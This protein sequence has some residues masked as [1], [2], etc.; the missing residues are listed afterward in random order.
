VSEATHGD[1][2]R[3]YPELP[4]TAHDHLRP[5]V[6]LAVNAGLRRGELFGLRWEDV[7]L[8]NALLTVVG[9]TAK[10]GTTRYVPLN[11]EAIL[12]FTDWMAPTSDHNGL[13]VSGK[14]GGRLDNINTAWR[15]LMKK[16]EITGF[17]FHDLRHHLASKLVRA[18]IDLD[19][20]RELLGH[21]DIKMTL[22]YAHLAPEHKAAAV[23]KLVAD[24]SPV[25]GQTEM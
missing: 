2:R 8:E 22:R 1:E 18:G 4:A 17:R 14:G 6:L 15:T 5:L 9:S 21:S 19:T 20:V 13:V 16:A 7:D 11:S 10:S 25:A 12:V 24:K 3:G 23:A